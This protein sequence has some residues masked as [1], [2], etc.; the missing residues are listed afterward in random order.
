MFLL[1]KKMNAVV[2]YDRVSYRFVWYQY[3][4][5]KPDDNINKF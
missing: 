5:I 3:V 1:C 4:V 2:H